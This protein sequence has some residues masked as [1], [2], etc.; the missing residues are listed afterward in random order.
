MDATT[1]QAL[2]TN[3]VATASSAVDLTSESDQQSSQEQARAL[4]AAKQFESLLLH[5]ML[6]SMRKT[7]LQEGTSNQRAIYDD[8]LDQ[9]MAEVL[10]DAGG[11]GVAEQL[12]SQLTGKQSSASDSAE[13]AA[14]H[15]QLRALISNN[16]L[17]NVV[18]ATSIN[19]IEPD[20]DRIQFASNLWQTQRHDQAL[21]RQQQF[22]RP[23]EPYARQ[24]AERLG[25]TTNTVLAIAALET[26]WGQS[27]LK[28]ATGNS[29]HNY[30][31]I[32]ATGSDQQYTR[33]A[34]TEFV[35]GIPRQVQ[36]KFKS[37]KDP[38]DGMHGFADFILENPR[39]SKALEHAD[40]P[41]RFLQE[42]QR[43]GYATDPDYAKKA[44]SILHQI[45]RRAAP[46]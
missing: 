46:L 18:P 29:A 31:G 3:P 24:S 41:E 2:P 28:D 42:I 22:I 10:V 21:S 20:K 6:K 25:T 12:M 43:A 23:L 34:T 33:N 8:M 37:Y 44:I 27:M 14:R 45:E 30:F 32:K 7:I 19:T 5:S 1:L 38:A 16:D 9:Q 15:S 40:Q 39:Y 11:L 36:A 17:H 13:L 35:N 26:G 4:E